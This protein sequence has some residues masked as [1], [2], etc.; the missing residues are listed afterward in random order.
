[1]PNKKDGLLYLGH[2]SSF[3][4]RIHGDE[5]ATGLDQADDLSVKKELGLF[6]REG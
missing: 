1:M 2:C 5:D 4:T 3:L 6:G